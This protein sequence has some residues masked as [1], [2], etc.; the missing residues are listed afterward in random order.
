MKISYQ[1]IAHY[2][3]TKLLVSAF[4]LLGLVSCTEDPNSPGVEF[5]PDMY[6]SIGYEAYLK[7][8]DVDSTD[9]F[10]RNLKKLGY[11]ESA[12]SAKPAII[13][14]VKELYDIFKS[15]IVTRKPVVGSVAQG[16]KPFM[17]AKGN[18]DDAK[19]VKMPIPY[20]E[21]SLFEGKSY[22]EIFCD[23]CH[24]EKGDGG[25]TLVK[26]D[27]F[28]KP[29]SYNVGTTKDLSAGEIYYTIYYGKGMMG[30]HSSQI[31]EEKRWKIVQYVQTLQG[32]KIEELQ[33]GKVP[34][35]PVV[36]DTTVTDYI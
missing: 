25:G 4:A 20:S 29:P 21:T 24:G 6:R 27:L 13:S 5:M 30:S 15:G 19:S 7:K 18:R 12:D 16:K 10:E 36:S 14:E 23:H 3:Y 11:E 31:T 26:K 34:V 28:L 35:N 1:K 2:A 33:G 8:F 17:I 22:Y 9:F 32:N